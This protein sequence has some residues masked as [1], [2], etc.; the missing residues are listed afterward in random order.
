MLIN[1]SILRAAQAFQ[2]KNDVRQ[3]LNGIMI[4][5][6]SIVGS[7]GHTAVLMETESDTGL[8]G[9]FCLA[10]KIPATAIETDLTETNAIHY[11]AK[12]VEKGRCAVV[13]LDLPMLSASQHVPNEYE[14][15]CSQPITL[16]PQFLKRIGDAFPMPK[17][18]RCLTRLEHYAGGP[19]PIIFT[20]KTDLIPSCEPIVLIMPVK[21]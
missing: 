19:T 10:G 20:V 14:L 8:K 16:Q 1:S 2:S 6:K 5:G 9:A 21:E 15:T 7:D 18:G 11:D 12:G 13:R 17:K 4:D 3:Q